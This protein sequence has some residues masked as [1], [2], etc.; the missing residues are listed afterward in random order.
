MKGWVFGIFGVFCLQVGFIALTG[1]DRP[2]ET[3]VAV[4]EVTNDSNPVAD[5]IGFADEE[6]FIDYESESGTVEV[7]GESIAVSTVARRKIRRS[8]WNASRTSKRFVKIP[9][10]QP[11]NFEPV[12]IAIRKHPPIQ[13]KTEYVA[14]RPAARA[15]DAKIQA[16]NARPVS[17][18]AKKSLA[19]KSLAVLKKPYD[20]LKA[21]GSRLK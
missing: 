4:N 2:F 1:I 8:T 9:E 11:V 12:I 10:P 17:K 5:T 3:M 16:A 7:L 18:T 20:W 13:F 19:S 6:E 21:L 14:L 15:S